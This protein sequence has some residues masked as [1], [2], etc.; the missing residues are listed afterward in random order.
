ML[1]L[2]LT[3]PRTDAVEQR[4][5]YLRYAAAESRGGQIGFFSQIARLEL[6]LPIDEEPIREALTYV[7]A[8]FDCSDFAI[9]GLLRLLHRHRRS[10]RLSPNLLAAIRDGVLGFKYWWDE[11]G[12]DPMCY[13]T[14][15]HQIIFY[16]DELLAGQLFAE[17]TFRNDG[18]N[19]N[20]HV[21]HALPRIRRWMDLR[22]IFG[23]SEW[24]SNCYLDEGGGPC[25]RPF[26]NG[27]LPQT[28]PLRSR[29]QH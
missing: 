10:R 9:A 18:R 28:E 14:E 17:R 19:G 26:R 23:F 1:D 3:S 6:D 8:R 16:S 22:A 15:N 25:G 2:D 24:L 27:A 7:A 20:A 21:T 11:P 5:Q 13:W 12:Q 4:L 29:R